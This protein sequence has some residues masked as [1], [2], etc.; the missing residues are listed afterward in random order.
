MNARSCRF[1]NLLIFVPLPLE[2]GTMPDH[3]LLVYTGILTMQGGS[4]NIF[5][6]RLQLPDGPLLTAAST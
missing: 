3:L 5:S 6:S 2:S 4:E 1:V